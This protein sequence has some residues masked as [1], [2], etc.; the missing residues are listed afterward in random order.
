MMISDIF[1]TLEISRSV[2]TK[3]LYEIILIHIIEPV[4]M[5]SMRHAFF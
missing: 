4:D 1:P 3:T 5:T 2:R